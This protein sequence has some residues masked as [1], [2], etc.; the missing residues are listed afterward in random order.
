MHVLIKMGAGAIGSS[1]LMP[2]S[3]SKG[4]QPSIHIN[5]SRVLFFPLLTQ[6]AAQESL[7]HMVA[8]PAYPGAHRAT[9]NVS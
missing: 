8:K 1:L 5:G 2:N 4:Q 3:R 7:R 9:R 6:P